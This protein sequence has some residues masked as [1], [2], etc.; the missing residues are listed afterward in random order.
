MTLRGGTDAPMAPP[1]G[2]LQHVFA[3]MARRLMGLDLEVGL[4]GL[5]S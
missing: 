2:Y 3:P 4:R 5:A 1:V